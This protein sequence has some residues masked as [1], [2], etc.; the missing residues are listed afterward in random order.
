MQ[1][2]KGQF[3][4]RLGRGY[5]YE[6]RQKIGM[7]YRSESK[8]FQLVMKKKGRPQIPYLEEL[9]YLMIAGDNDEGRK[10]A[11]RPEKQPVRALPVIAPAHTNEATKQLKLEQLEAAAREAAPE[12]DAQLADLADRFVGKIFWDCDEAPFPTYMVHEITTRGPANKPMEQINATCVEV[13]RCG[14]TS[15][16]FEVPSRCILG[17]GAS[18]IYNPEMLF[19][20]L[21]VDLNEGDGR[22]VKPFLSEYMEAHR[23]REDGLGMAVE[24]SDVGT[25]VEV[26]VSAP[27]P[28]G[29]K[30]ARKPK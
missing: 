2:L 8:P 23:Q 4:G 15:A 19:D 27:E 20:L 1:Y 3:T 30:R 14:K 28:G 29:R 12:D 17:T 13:V 6:N 22:V 18:A 7:Q 10:D 9:L 26:E 16:D 11:P 5:K 25:G 24:D 21:L